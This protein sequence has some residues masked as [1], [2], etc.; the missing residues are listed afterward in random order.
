M[1]QISSVRSRLTS[2]LAV[3]VMLIPSLLSAQAPSAIA[4]VVRD[5]TGAVM[6]GVT[7]EAASPALIE[8]VKTAATDNEG[9]YSI[10]DLRVGTYAVT[11]TLTGFN[12]V[13]REGIELTAGFTATVNADLQV[14]AVEETVS[15]TGASPLVDTQNVRQQQTVSATLLD[16]LPTS[17][18]ALNSVLVLTP[19][20]SGV[21]SG[22]GASQG[23]YRSSS[24][25]GAYHGKSGSKIQFDGMNIT[26]TNNGVGATGYIVNGATVEEMAV[27]TGG[28][29]AESAVSGFT[30]NFVPKDGGNLFSFIGSGV[31]AN[32]AL[33]SDNLTDELRARGLTT[34]TKVLKSYDAVA[35][36]GGPIKRDR[37]WF[38]AASR[39]TGNR[40]QYAGTFA[41]KTQNSPFYTADTSQPGYRKDYLWSEA[42]RLTWQASPRNKLTF[43]AD[44]QHNKVWGSSNQ[45]TTAPEAVVGWDFTPQ[46]LYQVAWSSPL[47]SKLLLEAGTSF[48]I[49]YWPQFPVFGATF[50]T[51]SVLDASTGFSYN[52]APA[53]IIPQDAR[54]FAQRFSASYITGTHSFKAGIQVEQGYNS[55]GSVIDHKTGFSGER[56][57]GNISYTFLGRTPNSLTEYAT[58][59]KQYAQVMPDL[60]I[61]AQD[62]WVVRRL[63]I[64]YGLRFDYLRGYVPPQEVPPT[65]F[66]GERKFD[67][68]DC[69]PCWKDIEPRLGVSYNL[70]GD[71]KTAVKFSI[72]RYVGKEAVTI[73][74]ANNPIQTSVNSVNRTWG[75]ANGNYFPDCDLKSAGA[76][77]ECGAISNVNFGQV[78]IATRYADDVLRGWGARDYLW[79]V[80]AELQ[81]QLRAG[82]SV[83][84]GYY[85]NWFGNFRVTDNLAVTPADY[86]PY[87]LT[88]PLNPGLP[89]GGGYQ[90]CGL[91]D[92]SLAKFGQANNIVDQASKYG[93]QSQVGNFFNTSLNARLSK[94]QV[95]GGIDTGRVVTDRCF[96]IDS[97]QELVNCHI[98]QPFPTNTQLKVSASYVLPWDMAV[99]GIFRNESALRAAAGGA[100]LSIEANYAAPNALIAPSLGRNLAACGA[101]T[102]CTAT[103]TVPLITPYTQF[104]PRLNQ[105][106]LRVTKTL[107]LPSKRARLQANVDL[108]NAL[109]AAPI[110]G[111]QT[112]FGSLWRY[113]TQ[114]LEGRLVQFS[115]KVTF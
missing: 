53:Y 30:V 68:V 40:N 79:D 38:F 22:V 111:I 83:S 74:N 109:N 62:Q 46:G 90:L 16:S 13:K 32:D 61:Y 104:E 72:G 114:V 99:S 12:A 50:D 7:V 76:N 28:A 27:E 54:R 41:N 33:Q 9:R 59:F 70:F 92:V 73:A 24:V 1:T 100:V 8:K 67:A 21:A 25:N 26:N 69:V 56:I 108:Y 34:G 80:A 87:C 14:G 97:P 94:L 95:G 107:R 19:G 96:V 85:R 52:A 31:F 78:N 51:I 112:T 42:I 20:L 81:H 58:P 65:P 48:A 64:N 10:T 93:K 11:F 86:S 110:T 89:G 4:G 49:S 35:T 15:V 6:P 43:F 71:G 45:I 57:D 55:Q 98:V 82:V 102:P 18:K 60:A 105:L 106:D 39:Y 77:G 63:T 115:G 5:T 113:P 23:T 36:L 2:I 47:S 17:S 66:V 103:A 88:A 44:V 3:G 101:R 75:D 91:Y 84:G 37:L 29:S